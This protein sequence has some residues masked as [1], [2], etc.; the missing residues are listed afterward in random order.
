MLEKP[1]FYFHRQHHIRSPTFGSSL[2][3]ISAVS[4]KIASMQSAG[5]TQSSSSSIDKSLSWNRLYH[6]PNNI[7]ILSLLALVTPIDG[8]RIIQKAT[9]NKITRAFRIY[10]SLWYLPHWCFMFVV[11]WTTVYFERTIYKQRCVIV[12]LLIEIAVFLN[13]SDNR[14]RFWRTHR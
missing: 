1:L 10:L 14:Y 8:R 12:D 9:F 2:K 7:L 11:V 13:W 4:F 6:H 5:K 3:I